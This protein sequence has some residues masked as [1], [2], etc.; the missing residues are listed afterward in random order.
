M[1]ILKRRKKEVNLYL[2]FT[3]KKKK[4]FTRENKSLVNSKLKPKKWKL[5]TTKVF[6]TTMNQ[7]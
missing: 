2:A 4:L 5:P 1:D 6:V 3:V 7:I